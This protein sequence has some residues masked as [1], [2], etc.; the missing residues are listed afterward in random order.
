MASLKFYIII[1]V[2]SFVLALFHCPK[3]FLFPIRQEFTVID[4]QGKKE[5]SYSGDCTGTIFLSI[6]KWIK[7]EWTFILLNLNEVFKG[8]IW[9]QNSVFYY[10]LFLLSN[11]PHFDS[12]DC[13]ITKCCFWDIPSD[14]FI[15]L[16]LQVWANSKPVSPDIKWWVLSIVFYWNFVILMNPRTHASENCETFEQTYGE[17]SWSSQIT[18]TLFPMNM[19][20]NQKWLVVKATTELL[21]RK[22]WAWYSVFLYLFKQV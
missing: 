11:Y 6:Q 2:S 10:I 15:S 22:G 19:C 9:M 1:I 5:V 3:Y 13:V 14:Y 4:N 20:S 12:T 17:M 21:R 18:E 16:W 8:I 7:V